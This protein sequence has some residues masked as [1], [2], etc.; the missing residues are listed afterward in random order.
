MD[1]SLRRQSKIVWSRDDWQ[2]IYRFTGAAIS[3]TTQ[4]EN[5]NRLI[6]KSLNYEVGDLTFNEAYGYGEI[7][8]IHDFSDDY[9]DEHK[10]HTRLDYH[11]Y[12]KALLILI[13]KTFVVLFI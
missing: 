3:L 10:T 2:S 6:I 1:K 7:T 11:L 12:V 5:K 13:E 4:F 8:E 9:L